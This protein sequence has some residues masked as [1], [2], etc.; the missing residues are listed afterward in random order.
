MSQLS[1]TYE[2]VSGPARMPDDEYVALCNQRYG[3][4]L[5]GDPEER[6]V[7]EFLERH[8][9]LVPGH[10]TPGA[11]SGHAP[12]HCSL[13]T[14]PKL[15]GLGKYIPD[16]MWVSTHSGAWFPTL[17]EIEKPGKNIFNKDGTPSAHFT[18][19]RNQLNQWRSWFG[20]PA[21]QLLF[22]RQYGVPDRMLARRMQLHMILIYGRRSEFENDGRLTRQRDT[23]LAG[24]DEELMSFDALQAERDMTQALTVKALYDGQYQAVHVPPVF[25]TGPDLADR[26]LSIK[27]IAEA[28]NKNPDITEARKTFLEH[29]IPYWREWASTP[30]SKLI[31]PNSVE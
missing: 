11:R 25:A 23:L 27:G 17:I 9:S 3:E 10:S 26:L 8:P 30:G 16:F 15:E 29:R 13:I 2:V 31:E 4:L 24:H 1:T 5:A 6:E 18:K 21:N 7:Q 19:A 28:I 22:S 20:D 12:L 14:Q